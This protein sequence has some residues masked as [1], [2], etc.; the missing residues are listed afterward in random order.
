[1]FNSLAVALSA[2]PLRTDRKEEARKWLSAMAKLG[3]RDIHSYTVQDQPY[4]TMND[5]LML[6][7]L[8][9][10]RRQLEFS[11][12]DLCQDMH[13]HYEAA[14]VFVNGGRAA[15]IRY[16]LADYGSILKWDRNT[17]ISKK[18]MRRLIR[19]LTSK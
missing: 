17:P 11:T 2:L 9:A 4:A 1:M 16:T 10:E 8:L 12:L 13:P 7:D 18:L 14:F 5:L 3:V 6:D 19:D 15:G